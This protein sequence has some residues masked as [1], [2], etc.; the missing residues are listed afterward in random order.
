MENELVTELQ[1]IVDDV[2]QNNLL[3][4]ERETIRRA[5]AALAT[6]SQPSS[7]EPVAFVVVDVGGKKR[8]IVWREAVRHAVE[9]ADHSFPEGAPHRL[10]G[11]YTHTANAAQIDETP[12][13]AR[14]NDITLAERSAAWKAWAAFERIAC[15]PG[16]YGKDDVLCDLIRAHFA[17]QGAPTFPAPVAQAA[18]SGEDEF[19]SD[20]E[21]DQI[22]EELRQGNPVGYAKAQAWAKRVLAPAP[23]QSGKGVIA[24]KLTQEMIEAACEAHYGK[25]QV[26]A[27]G[28]A[29]GVDATANGTNYTFSQAFRRMWR[30]AWKAAAQPVGMPQS[31]AGPS[32][33]TAQQYLDRTQGAASESWQKGW[34]ACRDFVTSSTPTSKATE[35]LTHTQPRNIMSENHGLDTDELVCFYEQDFYVLSN[36]SS[37]NLKR[38]GLTFPTSEHAY[39]WEKFAVDGGSDEQFAIASAI[40]EA[41]SAHEAF[42]IAERNKGWRRKDWDDV[43]VDIMRDI[44]RAKAQQHEYVRRKLLATG[45]RRLVENSWR[46][47]FWGWGPNRDGQNMLGKVWM[48]IRAE[49]RAHGIEPHKAEGADHG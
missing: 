35:P 33:P 49:L 45:D 17:S 8:R 31:G 10:E 1:H 37:F 9:N 38:E 11:L 13:A 20:A 19:V 4:K 32:I 2:V 28:G 47:D 14:H 23:G 26:H 36:F 39:H 30:G 3:R 46:D 44:L 21:F 48:E 27:V 22:T 16:Q 5:I 15:D 34:T 41:P 25:R 24:P 6:P 7:A 42:K 12:K 29:V 18:D 40:H 43:K